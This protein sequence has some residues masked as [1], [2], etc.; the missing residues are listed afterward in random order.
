MVCRQ[1]CIAVKQAELTEE[2]DEA[3]ERREAD[4]RRASSRVGFHSAS[5]FSGA[6]SVLLATTSEEG[7]TL[8]RNGSLREE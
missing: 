7:M 1:S 8:E 5:V 4:D 2:V 6:D 3:E